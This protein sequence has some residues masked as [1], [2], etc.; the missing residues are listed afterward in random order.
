[1]KFSAGGGYDPGILLGLQFWYDS[2]APFTGI[3]D[4]KLDALIDQGVAV[5]STS[6]R[7]KAYAQVY[8]YISDQAYSPV[9]FFA[10]LFNLTTKKVAG[11]GLTTQGAEIFWDQVTLNPK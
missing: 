3:K 9:L 8:K 10:P 2:H 11:P 6:G 5:S 7:A 1:M 4:P